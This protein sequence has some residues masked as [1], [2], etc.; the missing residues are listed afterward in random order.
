M[1]FE[2]SLYLKSSFSILVG[3]AQSFLSWRLGSYIE[4][5]TKLQ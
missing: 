4:K 2:N 3:G 1:I 5:E